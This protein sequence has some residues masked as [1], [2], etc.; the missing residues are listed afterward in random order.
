MSVGLQQ[1][2]YNRAFP[3]QH[4]SVPKA[5]EQFRDTLLPVFPVKRIGAIPSAAPKGV[6]GLGFVFGVRAFSHGLYAKAPPNGRASST[7]GFSHKSY[8]EISMSQ[9]AQPLQLTLS[10]CRC[11]ACGEVGAF[12]GEL[13]PHTFSAPYYGD[14]DP[15]FST[16]AQFLFCQ[17]G[18]TTPS[19]PRFSTQSLYGPLV[20]SFRPLVAPKSKTPPPFCAKTC[21]SE[22]P[23]KPYAVRISRVSA[24]LNRWVWVEVQDGDKIK[25]AWVAT[26]K[27]LEPLAI[28][29]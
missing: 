23:R 5:T 29:P 16:M 6:Y 28:T 17:G 4:L 1:S 11:L 21:L 7:L 18:K 15:L 22:T 2:V 20:E 14:N 27:R 9:W 24:Y 26:P 10:S 8:H 3:R 19:T 13:S 25:S 12:W